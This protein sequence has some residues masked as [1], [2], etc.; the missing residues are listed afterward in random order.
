M[1]RLS[2]N[3]SRA[4]AA[5]PAWSRAYPRRRWSIASTA[6]DEARRLDLPEP[7][8][9]LLELGR[10]FLALARARRDPRQV[11]AGDHGQERTCANLERGDAV[12]W[13]DSAPSVSRGVRR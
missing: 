12:G 9:R 2:L 5:S 13:Q 10:R 3:G 7:G 11:A 8:E 1:R 4:A 6:A